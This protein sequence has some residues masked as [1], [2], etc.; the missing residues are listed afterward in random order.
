MTVDT[1]HHRTR[2]TAGERRAQIVEAAIREFAHGGL[3]GASTE[4]IA[5]RAGISHAYLFRLFGTK[6]E[7]FLACIESAHDRVLAAFGAAA[8]E[9]GPGPIQAQLG[10]AYRRLV[11]DRDVLMFQ[12]HAFAV[13]CGDDQ[14]RAVLGRR[15]DEVFRWVQDEAGLDP[16]AARLFMAQGL[17]V[18]TA[19]ALDLPSLE[20]H[21]RWQVRSTRAL[22]RGRQ[23]EDG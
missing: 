2:L 22:L 3:A 4:A 21:G 6:R 9:G 7:L 23:N 14:V 16:D 19:A 5:R 1:P 13:A 8:A 18:N 15:Y 10:R 12:L 17:L 20:D 11:E